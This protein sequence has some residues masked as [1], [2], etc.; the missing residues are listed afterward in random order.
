[1]FLGAAALPIR[2]TVRNFD[3]F[4][5]SVINALVK[6][7]MKYDPNPTRDGDFNTIARGSTS[8]IAKEVLAASLDAVRQTVTPDE[9]PHIKTRELLKMRLQ[10]RDVPVEMIMEDEDKANQTIE[11]NRKAQQSATEQQQALIEAQVNET[12]AKAVAAIAKAHKDDASINQDAAA[13]LVEALGTGHANAIKEKQV[14]KPK[15][16][17]S[18]NK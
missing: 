1:M 12:L 13:L 11:A 14:D 6:W 2:D 8:L 10:A 7:N 5:M 15:E 18:G 17:A 4:T 3:S 9:A 16:A